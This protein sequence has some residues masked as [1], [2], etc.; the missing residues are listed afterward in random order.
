V[1]HITVTFKTDGDAFRQPS[2]DLDIAEAERVLRLA[3]SRIW[4]IPAGGTMKLLDL[5]GN[6]CGLLTVEEDD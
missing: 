6:T 5:N 4:A 2:G 1:S 3:L